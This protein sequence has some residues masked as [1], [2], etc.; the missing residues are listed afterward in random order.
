MLHSSYVKAQGNSIYTTPI[1]EKKFVGR[2]GNGTKT[3]DA[4]CATAHVDMAAVVSFISIWLPL[5]ER[6]GLSIS[7]LARPLLVCI[8]IS[9][10]REQKRRKETM[11]VYFLKPLFHRMVVAGRS[12]G[13]GIVGGGRLSAGEE[14]IETKFMV[15]VIYGRHVEAIISFGREAGRHNLHAMEY[16]YVYWTFAWLTDVR[17]NY[18]TGMQ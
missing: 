4:Q 17:V 11:A 16:R 8:Q 7:P 10:L 9:I 6:T 12:Y 5:H 1:P 15:G 2:R 13:R 18:I 3:C 14:I